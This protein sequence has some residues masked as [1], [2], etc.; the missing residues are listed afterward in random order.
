MLREFDEKIVFFSRLIKHLELKDDRRYYVHSNKQ[1][2]RQKI[3]QIIAGYPEDS[4]ANQLTN[5][6]VFPQIVGKDARPVY[7]ACSRDLIKNLSNY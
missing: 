4:A 3:Y 1:L 2:H 5:D 6:P 7:R